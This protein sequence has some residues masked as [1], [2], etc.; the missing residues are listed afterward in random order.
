M[1]ITLEREEVLACAIALERKERPHDWD[2]SALSKLL[3]ALGLKPKSSS[4]KEG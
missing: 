3:K 2:K 4:I 1:K